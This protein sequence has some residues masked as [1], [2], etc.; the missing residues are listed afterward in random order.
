MKRILI[1][2]T[3]GTITMQLHDNTIDATDSSQ[4]FNL[5]FFEEQIPGLQEIARIASETL[6]LEDSSNMLPSHW[7]NIAG[8]IDDN[9]ARYDGFV[10]LHGTDTMAYTASALSFCFE[11][12]EKPIVLTGSQVPLGNRRTDARR[13]LINS[14][15]LATLNIPE[16]CICFNDRVYRGNRATKISIGDFDAFSSPNHPVL[17]EFGLKLSIHTSYRPGSGPFATS[18][19]FDPGI[20]LVK[21]FPGMEGSWMFPETADA[22]RG[23][24]VEAYGS[25]NIPY[26]RQQ[27]IM[28]AL[29]RYI[30]SGG[31]AVIT[32][33]ALHDEVDLNKYE[34][35]RMA[36]KYGAVSGGDMTTEACVSKL[37]YLL[38][39][40][41]DVQSVK[42][43]FRMN[44]AGER[45]T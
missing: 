30:D 12:L 40:H 41:S 9:Y 31:V 26:G 1:L 32:S 42:E 36:L 4:P 20:R 2:H 22:C 33:Q 13:N 8:V 14:V 10:I 21:L 35:G 19:R 6:F 37:M 29:K 34:G 39:H 15:E 27:S 28:P 24:V 45:S 18:A 43:R 38:A 17:A 16:V 25:G 23:V 3:G 5:A 7:A 11:N 44:L